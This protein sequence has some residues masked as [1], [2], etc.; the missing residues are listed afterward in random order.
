MFPLG[1]PT[2]W[3][4]S[5]WESILDLTAEGVR[6]GLVLAVASIGLSLVFGVTGLTNFAHGE[7][8]TFGALVAFFFS[9]SVFQSPAPGRRRCSRSSRAALFGAANELVLFRPLRKRRSGTCR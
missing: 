9:V 8:V 5:A 2:G 4:P 6:F 3:A 7:L 1:E